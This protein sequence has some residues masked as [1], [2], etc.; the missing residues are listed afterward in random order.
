MNAIQT[1]G[2]MLSSVGFGVTYSSTNDVPNITNIQFNGL[3]LCSNGTS[4]NFIII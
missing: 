1:A 4:H 3:S 2:N